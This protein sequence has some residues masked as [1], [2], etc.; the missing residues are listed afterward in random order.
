[1]DP[2]YLPTLQA[3]FGDGV[4]AS[5]ASHNLP[6][7]R[8]PSADG[9]QASS[10]ARLSFT[11]AA[12]PVH[13][14]TPPGLHFSGNAVNAPN[15]M[16]PAN[17]ALSSCKPLTDAVHASLV[18][19]LGIGELTA[20]VQTGAPRT[21][22]HRH[23]A[24]ANLQPWPE[25]PLRGFGGCVLRVGALDLQLQTEAGSKF[26]AGVPAFEDLPTDM[27]LGADYLLSGEVRLTVDSAGVNLSLLTPSTAL[28]QRSQVDRPQPEVSADT[29][30][31]F[32]DQ[33]GTHLLASQPSLAEGFAQIRQYGGHR[34]DPSRR[35][36]HRPFRKS[37]APGRRSHYRPL[38]QPTCE[39]GDDG[40][41]SILTPSTPPERRAD[42]DE[43]ALAV[44]GSVTGRSDGDQLDQN[45]EMLSETFRSFDVER[46]YGGVH[47][48]LQTEAGS[49]FL[50]G[51]PAFEDLPTDMILGADYLLSGEVRLTVDSA[52]VNLS[53]L[54][55][56][57][58]SAQRSQVDRPQP[59][60]SS[61]T[62]STFCDQS[63]TH[64]LAS[65][66]SLAEG[67]AQ[68]SQYGGHPC[69]P[70]RRSWHRPLRKSSAP[71]RRSHYRPFR[72]P[73]CESGD[74]VALGVTLLLFGAAEPAPVVSTTAGRI[75][76]A[77]RYA[78]EDRK[79]YSFTG[80][81]FAKPPLGE[82]RYKKPQPPLPWGE[83]VL[84]ATRTPPSCMQLSVFSARY[85]LWVPYDRPKSEDCLYLNIWT[86]KLGAS[87]QLPVM[88]WLHGGD[89]QVGSPAMWLDD[90]GN[91]AAL[92]DVVVVTIAYRLQSY[93][94]LYDGT[95]EAPGNQAFHDQVLALKWIQDN[96]ETFGGDPGS[97]TLFGWSAGGIAAGFHLLSPRSGNLFARVIIQ[98]AGVTNSDR[99]LSAATILGYTKQFA[100]MF[101]CKNGSEDGSVSSENVACLRRIDATVISSVEQTF[102]D[103]GIGQFK[104]IYGD[105]F[106]PVD[107][108]K[109]PFR[110]DKDV[111][112]GHVANEGSMMIYESFRDTF[113]QVLAPR[114]INKAEM[115]HYLGSLYSDL[116]LSGVLK[117]EDE[118]MNST[119]DFDY[120]ALRQAFVQTK[121]DSHV[122]C[123]TFITASKLSNAMATENTGKGVYV[124][125]LDYISRC[126]KRPPWFGMTHGD[127][128]PLEFGRPFDR[129]NG[130][131]ADIPF[132]RKIINV[133]TNFAK[134]RRP[135]GPCGAEW[136]LFQLDTMKVLKIAS[137]ETK[138]TSF[139]HKN[140]CA[141]LKNLELY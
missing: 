30:S 56:S 110:G 103:Q 70:S 62:K 122:I 135:S 93:G 80:I 35:S 129:E 96:I 60:V 87:A 114:K 34:C 136:P 76:G 2:A 66:P 64:L 22:L 50:A 118:Y 139:N 115:I 97:V 71:G 92:G 41:C 1:M 20:L 112:M 29:K 141:L 54:T 138:I 85:L 88:A 28:A 133:W 89:F 83:D 125:E 95:E 38:R 99:T 18:H 119:G 5:W 78:A 137:G 44:M 131:K 16:D 23:H 121:S 134:G 108:R 31:T 101:G 21:A 19:V 107:N 11:G 25:A 91:L 40:K 74:D 36:R 33:S 32:C 26:L 55:P 24:P 46:K 13:T 128:T 68:I 140:R 65:Q 127:E 42:Q 3:Q 67:F 75:R 104:P 57:T 63:G 117:I 98:S 27:I 84:D 90:G 132:S 130:C 124:Y 86:P 9:V 73:T 59:E 52:G 100:Q 4:Y 94:F 79:V 6:A 72:Q 51:V 48:H 82:L 14:K 49:K 17:R 102:V 37:S 120:D 53:P 12:V 116:S 7:L 58:A 69:D 123:G 43:V 106:L 126:N 61:D 39:S 111:I 77:L 47:V 105:E 8:T 45:S 81:P 15:G 109:A 10:T 113:S